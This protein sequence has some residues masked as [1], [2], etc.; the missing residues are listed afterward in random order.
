[1]QYEVC[2]NDKFARCMNWY[3]IVYHMYMY[4]SIYIIYNT[5]YI[6]I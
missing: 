5:I 2:K 1:M 4:T 6:C 3:D